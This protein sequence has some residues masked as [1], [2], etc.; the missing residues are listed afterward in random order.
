M[1]DM[2]CNFWRWIGGTERLQG[3]M[4]KKSFEAAILLAAFASTACDTGSN[5]AATQPTDQPPVIEP[6]PTKPE[7][8]IQEPLPTP[9]ELAES[10]AD[11]I[12]NI[13]LARFLE[14][15]PETNSLGGLRIT[16]DNISA[17]VYPPTNAT[18]L[19][20][21]AVLE[22]EAWTAGFDPNPDGIAIIVESRDDQ[23]NSLTTQELVIDPK[24]SKKAEMP[25]VLSATIPAEANDI[26]LTFSK[27]AN[28]A[29]DNTTV[30][31]SYR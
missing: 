29:F 21:S 26:Q 1:A 4:S 24:V 7:R 5:T 19:V 22:P 14:P 9:A 28:G 6:E 23:G 25:A 12:G 18:A 27:R 17:V 13:N 16:P 3:R 31:F 8:T 10:V 11:G 30:V 20:L 15:G 2:I